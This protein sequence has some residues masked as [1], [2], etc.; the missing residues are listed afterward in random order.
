MKLVIGIGEWEIELDVAGLAGVLICALVSSVFV[1]E[2]WRGGIP[3][4]Q[5]SLYGIP[6]WIVTAVGLR[7]LWGVLGAYG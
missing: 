4:R 7:V 3:I 6:V 5:A 2:C 1:Y